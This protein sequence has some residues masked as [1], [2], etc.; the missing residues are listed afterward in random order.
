MGAPGRPAKGNVKMT[1]YVPAEIKQ[2]IR[3]EAITRNM[4][5]GDV[6]VEAMLRRTTVVSS[7]NKNNGE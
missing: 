6:V 3:I 4:S 7:P 1:C 2:A 5:I